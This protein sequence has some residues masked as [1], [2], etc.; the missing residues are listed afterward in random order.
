MKDRREFERSKI[1][2][3]EIFLDRIEGE[4]GVYEQVKLIIEE[5]SEEGM[6]FWELVT[7]SSRDFMENTPRQKVGRSNF[8]ERH[9]LIFF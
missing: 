5:V 6:R 8:P 9:F 3:L 7:S 2:P 4:N 1:P